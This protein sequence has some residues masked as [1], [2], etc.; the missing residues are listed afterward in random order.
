MGRKE[1]LLLVALQQL[2]TNTLTL[3]AARL[4]VG[5]Q[6]QVQGL[7]QDQRQAIQ[8]AEYLLLVTLQ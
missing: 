3:L 6:H 4:L 1:F 8:L 5:W 2:A 7:M